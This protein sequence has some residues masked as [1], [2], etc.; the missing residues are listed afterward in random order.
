MSTSKRIS[1]KRFLKQCD[2]LPGYADDYSCETHIKSLHDLKLFLDYVQIKHGL[3]R[4]YCETPDYPLLDAR[5]L[6]PSFDVDCFENYMLPGF[7]MVA[8]DRPLH[9]FRE[10]FQFNALHPRAEAKN[11]SGRINHKLAAEFKQHNLSAVLAHLPR[12]HHESFRARF[13]D[14]DITRLPLYPHILPYLFKM[15]RAQ[16]FARNS[17]GSFCLKGVYASFPS[18]LDAEIKRF[19]LH[20]GKFAKGDEK[21]YELNRTFVYQF[22]M[23]M[24]GFPISSERR[25][26]AA[27]F[28]RRLHR[29]QERFFIRVLGQTDRCLTT[30][31]NYKSRSPYLRVE[32]TALVQ[33][34]KDQKDVIK[35]LDKL[36]L[37]VDRERRAVLLRVTYQPHKY[38][39]NNVRQD[40]ALSTEGQEIIHPVTGAVYTDFNIVKDSRSLFLRLNDI[41]QGEYVGKTIFKR[42]EVV[43]NTE[44][45]ENRLKFLYTWLTKHQRRFIS[46]SDEF[47]ANV[48]R[49]LDGY[50]L[51]PSRQE[52][53][54]NVYDLY[55]DV[56][57]KYSY[58]Q[59]A[60]KV[61]LLEDIHN[62]Q[63]RGERITYLRMYSD[64]VTLLHELKFEIAEYFDP[65]VQHVIIFGEHMLNDSYVI[66]NYIEGPED[67]LTA[68]GQEVRRN[69]KKLV[70]L[71]D[72]FVAIRR[73]R[74]EFIRPDGFEQPL[75][76]RFA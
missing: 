75:N 6:L 25:T 35:A 32:K 14:V 1:W 56:L 4:A 15:D 16:V 47:Y 46:Y 21:A 44:S 2:L 76:V 71:I 22:L 12:I 29:M 60:R 34:D 23:E 33:V 43:E 42:T 68:Y 73:A 53:F 70:A 30:I 64:A 26:S 58:I 54:D 51:S 39:A 59:Q 5:E 27:M 48:A 62:R 3:L 61:R 31:A 55:Q 24:Y 40:R 69:Y 66:K 11:S 50:L 8:F 45:T 17:A 18:D 13:A 74:L 63:V 57:S 49:V 72:E 52:M 65:L 28:A 10:I 19:G 38:D 67:A 7:S 9:S 20:I 41:V 36:G 37:F